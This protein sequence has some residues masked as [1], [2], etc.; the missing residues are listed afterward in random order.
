MGP[1]NPTPLLINTTQKH[2]NYRL[3]TPNKHTPLFLHRFSSTANPQVSFWLK[4][5][6][7]TLELQ[8]LVFAQESQQAFELKK[9]VSLSSRV[10]KSF[11]QK[12]PQAFELNK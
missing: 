12:F 3:R 4:S 10:S 11:A 8:K 7:H 9:E 1:Q 6:E 2:Q 5:F